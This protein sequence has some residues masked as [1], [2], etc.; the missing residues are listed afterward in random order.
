MLLQLGYGQLGFDAARAG[1]VGV[2]IDNAIQQQIQQP[3]LAATQGI[4]L[5]ATLRR[6]GLLG[7]HGWR[8]HQGCA[9]WP[10]DPGSSAVSNYRLCVSEDD[11]GI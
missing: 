1:V 5:N 8:Y 11:L 7:F 9:C 6:D 4:G 10:C 3:V 2:L